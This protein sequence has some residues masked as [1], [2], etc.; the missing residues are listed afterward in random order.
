MKMKWF[1]KKYLLKK[2]VKSLLPGSVVNHRKQGFVGPMAQWLKRDLRPYVLETLS[3]KNLKGHGL[4]DIKTVRAILDEHFS[5]QEIHD[6]LIWS[7]LIFQ[8]WYDSYM[9]E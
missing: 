4:F 8:K 2:A 9:G 7:L 6:T 5:G 1:R 3:E